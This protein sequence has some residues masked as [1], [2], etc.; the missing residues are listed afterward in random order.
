MGEAAP[1]DEAVLMGEVALICKVRSCSIKTLSGRCAC[2]AIK[3][4]SEGACAAIKTL[5]EGGGRVRDCGRA[6]GPSLSDAGALRGNRGG[7]LCCPGASRLTD[8]KRWSIYIID[9]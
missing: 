9:I 1:M 4:L 3:T 7:E 8:L 5:A 2:S 6:W